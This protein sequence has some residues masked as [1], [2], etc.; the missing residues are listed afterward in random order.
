MNYNY[1]TADVFTEQAFHGV[2]LPVFPD[3]NGLSSEKM[4]Q[5]AGELSTSSTIF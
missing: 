3:A 2:P 4:Q 5:I 1:Y